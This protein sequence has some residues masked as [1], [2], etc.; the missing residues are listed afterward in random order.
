MQNCIKCKVEFQVFLM[1]NDKFSKKCVE[2]YDK[3]CEREKNR[4]K[5]NRKY[6][7]KS[8]MT[9]S[10]LE[11]YQR[12]IDRYRE[13]GRS[14][15]NTQKHREHKRNNL[16][17]EVYLKQ[18]AK[19]A[20]N[21]RSK[22]KEHVSKWNKENL[23]RTL[24]YYKRCAKEKN[25]I[26]TLIDCYVLSLF[27]QPCYYCGDI[28]DNEK[29]TG[30]DRV[31]NSIGYITSNIV[32]CCKICNMMKKDLDQTTFIKRCRHIAFIN[33]KIT[34]GYSEDY[35]SAESFG[36]YKRTVNYSQYKSRCKSN[37]KL[38]MLSKQ[39][40]KEITQNNCYICNKMN[41]QY[42]QNGIDRKDNEMEYIMGNCFPCCGNCNY[43]KNK[44]DYN[45]ILDKCYKITKRNL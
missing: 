19:Q 44:F 41:T 26:W 11:T 38:L 29:L 13:S 20:R 6:P 36:D 30:I 10:Q 39:T 24:S 16:G 2:C 8:E 27:K 15:L 42:H 32:P 22:N 12:K 1:K 4:P 3:E 45:K 40:F 35:L 23:N 18:N 33:R 25:N 34:S 17:N 9:Q 31:D 7:K 43:F 37:H 28:M 14:R 5:R 21:W